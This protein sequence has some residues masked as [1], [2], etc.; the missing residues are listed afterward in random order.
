MVDSRSFPYLSWFADQHDFAEGRSV[1][2][3][4]TRYPADVAV[5]DLTRR[6][7]WLAFL[8]MPDWRPIFYGPTAAVFRR[9]ADARL[10]DSRDSLWRW[11]TELRNASTALNAFEFATYIGDYRSGWTILDDVRGPLAYQRID[12]ARRRAAYDYQK[13]YDALNAHRYDEAFALLESGSRDRVISPHDDL[14][15]SLLI[16]LRH[17]RAAGQTAESTAIEQRLAE[18]AAPAARP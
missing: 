8:D 17:A 1:G 18:L 14:V 15:H 16:D 10:L 6:N 13:A 9:N 4:L 11:R 5:I 2:R 3:F 7:T 12:T